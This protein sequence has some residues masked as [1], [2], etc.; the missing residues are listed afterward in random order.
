MKTYPLSQSQLGVFLEMMQHPQM[1]QY[2]LGYIVPLPLHVDFD[3][4]ELAIK[5]IYMARPEWRIRFLMEGE[6]P[7]QTVDDT[8]PL[9]ITRLTLTEAQCETYLREARQPFDPF[10]DVLCRFW[11]IELPKRKILAF[12]FCHLIMD[13][14]SIALLFVKR[15]LPFA[16]AECPRSTGKRLPPKGQIVPEM[17]YGILSWAEE[18]GDTFLTP[19]YEKD[20]EYY[21]Q[22]FQGCETISL[23]EK[24]SDPLGRY[25]RHD[26]Y[27]PQQ[28]VTS[29]CDAHGTAPNLLFMA[30]FAYALSV[31]G[32][33]DSFAF[34]TVNHGR[35]KRQMRQA[36]GMFVRTVPIRASIHADTKVIDFI[37]SFRA[38]LSGTI[39]HSSYPFTHFFRDLQI[40][41][42]NNFAFQSG[43]ITEELILDGVTYPGIS[44]ELVT[45]C[46]D[47]SL[48]VYERDGQYDLRLEASDRLYSLTF[49]QTMTRM[50]KTVAQNMMLQPESTLA[51][52]SLV[53]DEEQTKL[54]RLGTGK[55]IDID[56]RDTF[57]SAFERQAAKTPERMAVADGI[58]QLTYAELSQRSNLLAHLLIEAGV[59]PDGFLQY[60][61][62]DSQA[63]VLITSHDLLEEKQA[64]GMDLPEGIRV[65]FIDDVDFSKMAEPINL[66]TPDGLAYMIYTSG[67]TGN[68]KGVMVPHR[69]LSHVLQFIASEWRMSSESRISC[70][71]SFAFD[72]SLED[73]FAVLTVGGTTFIVPEEVTKDLSLLH[74]FILENRITGGS[75]IPQ[76][77]QMLLQE[78]PDLPVEYM[79]VGGDKMT[80]VPQSNCRLINVY[81]PT[82]FT[83]DATYYEFEQ[84]R[85]YD[86]IPIGRPLHNQM[87]F[88]VDSNKHLLPKG[89]AGELC[90]AGKQMA[91][92]YWK[93]EEL[94]REK[95]T[96]CPFVEGERMYRTGDLC[97]WNEQ[98]QL[99]YIGRID[100]QVKLRGFRVELG[101]IES[102]SLKYDGIKQTVANV[103]DGQLLCLYYTADCDIDEEAL[104]EYL[105]QSL[106]DYMVPAVYIHLEELPLTPNG[107][108]DR[109]RLPTPDMVKDEIVPPATPLEQQLFDLAAE[110]LG[111]DRFGVTSNLISLGL[112]SIAAMRLSI[113]IHQETGSNLPVRDILSQPTIRQ[114]AK[115][116]NEGQD[117][118]QVNLYDYHIIQEF[119]PLTE[120]QRG[121]YIDWEMNRDTT[122]Y[123]MPHVF[124]FQDMDAEKLAE[125][126]RKVVDAHSYVKTRFVIHDGEVMQHRRDEE[127]AQVSVTHLEHEPDTA[128][129]QSR[130]RP[131][132]PF[133]DDL[134]R[135]DVYAYGGV[136]WL[137]KDFHHLVSDGLSEEVFY[138]D[139]MALIQGDSI[140]K[141]EVTAFDFALYEQELKK[142]E[143]FEEAEEY[144]DKL[145][146]GAEAVSYPHSSHTD[147]T[148]RKS[149]TL[150]LE[151]TEGDRIW[152]ACRSMGITENAYFQTVLTQV[153]HR[154]TREESIMLA[155][156]TSGRQLS[157]MERMVG[158]FVRTIPLVSVTQAKDNQTFADAA[159]AMHRQSIESV[160]SDFYPLTEVVERHGLRPQ[161]LYA[162]EGGLYDGVNL[163][164]DGQKSSGV[165][166]MPLTLDTQKLPIEL[167]IFP[168]G[169]DGYTIGLSYDTAL[170]NRQDMMTL[171]RTLTAFAVNASM[172]GVCLADIEMVTDEEQTKLI[173]L[174]TG[175]R[176][177]YDQ[178]ETLV[179]LFRAQAAKTPDNIAVVFKDRQLTYRELDDLTDHLAAHLINYYHVQPEEAIGVMTD[180]SELMAVYPLAIMKAGAAYMP[181]DFNF[182]EERLQYMCQDAEVRLILSQE[183]RVYHAMPSFSG[184]VFTSDALE[185]LPKCSSPLP[186]PLPSHRYVILY[187]LHTG[188][189]SC[190]PP[191]PQANPKVWHWS[192]MA[193]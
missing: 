46:G 143:R 15:D 131:F 127:P 63:T 91:R 106:P 78:Y 1:T 144:F 45:T 99:E 101:E 136:T 160:S 148:D 142:S 130:V 187:C 147:D 121:V 49:L 129:F 135:L 154:I 35:T 175:E 85:H 64:Q 104:K 181:L 2:N 176:M 122:Q 124:R 17:P 163:N 86:N 11:L 61:L 58:G 43:E 83:I 50:I 68:P 113:A 67:S 172:D 30:A 81:G 9:T 10:H 128:F 155:T 24:F 166:D 186:D 152:N 90:L 29:W 92:G 167:T 137:F 93:Q 37:Q 39:R 159:R 185:T 6:E 102:R 149:D 40:N 75:Y 76:I 72:A 87:A 36:Y 69:A 52:L 74:H 88:I 54:I 173:K 53:D 12:D 27:L 184:D 123:N 114:I 18:Q 158:M 120:N 110:R 59:Q 146:E 112:T 71:S 60:I 48:V 16:Y 14:I 70:Q 100:T 13:G 21:R 95:F 38:E 174:G 132:N 22:H 56:I 153:L 150:T 169:K 33:Q 141:E 118:A 138:H 96:D 193:S 80:I 170:Y 57:V 105:A 28:E 51:S 82:E 79:V 62:E 84:E 66:A 55:H 109:K 5:A 41:P 189:S 180:R 89:L 183:D 192:T 133:E 190:T 73:L 111:T 19:T 134:Y 8:R 3:R 168:N 108:V 165:S 125:A 94:S 107:K 116:I 126:L 157:G 23:V 177:G 4:L 188:M 182:P 140:E 145:L 171:I 98:G 139:L 47:L 156:I 31:A 117:N 115:V 162:Y 32:R 25:I 44:W 151:I 191:A 97:R 119:Y 178:S 7:R 164:E 103:H 42:L 34:T 26:E 77:G 65:I 179:S 20:K 161:I